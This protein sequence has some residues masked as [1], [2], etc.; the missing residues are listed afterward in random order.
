MLS[1]TPYKM[2]TKSQ[3]AVCAWQRYAGRHD[4]IKMSSESEFSHT[5]RTENVHIVCWLQQQQQIIF[6]VS[7]NCGSNCMHT[8]YVVLLWVFFSYAFS[9][10]HSSHLPPPHSNNPPPP[11]SLS[12]SLL[13]LLVFRVNFHGVFMWIS[14]RQ[15]RGRC[16]L[17]CISYVRFRNSS[18]NICYI[19]FSIFFCALFA[20]L[21]FRNVCVTCLPRC[22][23]AVIR[24][25]PSLLLFSSYYISFA[26]VRVRQ[27]RVVHISWVYVPYMY[28][29][30]GVLPSRAMHTVT[31]YF[32]CYN[33]YGEY[34]ADLRL[35]QARGHVTMA[36]WP[37]P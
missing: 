17:K 21:N 1:R 22:L 3:T 19:L 4:T 16:N 14:K 36:Q 2:F 25:F 10:N 30:V 26:C 18:S 31:L 6:M 11:L 32:M 35:G 27:K 33:L 8:R 5:L 24:Q 28:C 37:W 12:H 20:W 7:H 34:V 13:L 15:L 9:L 29:R 23:S